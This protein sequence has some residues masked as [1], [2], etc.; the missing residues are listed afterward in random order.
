[1]NFIHYGNRLCVVKDGVI[2][3]IPPIS[4][5]VDDKK[6]YEFFKD[7]G[8]LKLNKNMVPEGQLEKMATAIGKNPEE[9]ICVTIPLP[10]HSPA[11]LTRVRKVQYFSET[12]INDVKE[13]TLL[14]NGLKYDFFKKWL[15]RN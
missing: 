10:F 7:S 9:G 15:R 8:I 4:F 3:E 5:S 12:E 13:D 6:V 1:M 11:R 14:V 2:E